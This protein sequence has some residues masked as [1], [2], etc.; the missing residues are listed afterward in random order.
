MLDK[1]AKQISFKTGKKISDFA[2]ICVDKRPY[3]FE[4]NKKDNGQC[5]FLSSKNKCNIYSYR[6][7]ICKFYPF[8]L[9][10]R[11]NGKYEFLSTNECP[12]IDQGN[13]LD[14]KY[15]KDLFELANTQFQG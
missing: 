10:N 8:E 2:T 6:P 14:K 4:M 5:V 11:I 1:E 3:L 13:I 9:I 7:L 15:F 12:G